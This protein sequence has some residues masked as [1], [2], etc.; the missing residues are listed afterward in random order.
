MR[1]IR[2]RYSEP[3]AVRVHHGDRADVPE[4]SAGG[5]GEPVKRGRL[6]RSKPLKADPEA[7]RAWQDRSRVPLERSTGLRRT[8]TPVNPPRASDGSIFD[9]VANAKAA[10]RVWEN[11]NFRRR[12]WQLDDGHCRMCGVILDPFGSQWEW[13]AHHPVEK[14]HLPEE[15]R[16]SPDGAC[17]VCRR[18]HE[19]HH[20]RTAV[21]P[22]ERLPRRN[23]DF[24]ARL[25]AWA[26]VRLERAHPTSGGSDA[27]R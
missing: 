5:G 11:G 26:E 3:A 18:C 21:I 16:G 19:R 2:G 22:R 6:R 10:M 17:L 27:R 12:V 24:V 4:C 1:T 20:S 15:L 7:I 8:G 23:L 9:P 14:Q 13:V 25:G